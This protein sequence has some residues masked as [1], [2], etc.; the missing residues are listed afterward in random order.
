MG[1]QVCIENLLDHHN[2]PENIV[3]RIAYSFMAG[4]MMTLVLNQDG[5]INWNW[6]QVYTKIDHVPEQEPIK[7]FVKNAN[8]WRRGMGKKY[9]HTGKMVKPYNVNCK[10]QVIHGIRG[11]DRDYAEVYTSAWTDGKNYGQFLINYNNRNV[12]CE[13]ELPDGEYTLYKN[14]NEFVK[15]SGGKHEIEIS[16]VDVIMIEK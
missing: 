16:P 6:G 1:N 8:A 2:S 7:E 4:D 15:I 12:K 11:N 14:Q 13:I 10:T 3:E 9:L 5:E